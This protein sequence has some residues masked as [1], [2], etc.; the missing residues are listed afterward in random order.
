[1]QFRKLAT[2]IAAVGVLGL[3]QSGAFAADLV[4]TAASA[5][6][7]KTLVKAV[8]AAGLVDTL[9]ARGPYTVFAP[10]DEAFAKL[11]PGTLDALLAD[12][13]KLASVLKYHVVSGKVMAKDVK[14]GSVNTVEGQ[15]LRVVASGNG[16]TVNDAT[17]VTT[18][19]EASNGV[20]HVIDRV[21]LPN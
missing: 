19:I 13:Q 11:P 10:T 1:M 8:Q 17:V 5:G 2:T 6:Q 16:V 18:D 14:T 20:I 15:P 7:F 3:A 21:V 4:D 12:P 9:K